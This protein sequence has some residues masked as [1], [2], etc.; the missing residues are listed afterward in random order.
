LYGLA[1]AAPEAVAIGTRVHER[2]RSGRGDADSLLRA[3]RIERHASRHDFQL[4]NA[5]LGPLD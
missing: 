5:V 3:H 1:Q 4:L 2:Q